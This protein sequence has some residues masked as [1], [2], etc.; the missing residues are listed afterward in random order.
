[1]T[2]RAL[3]SHLVEM[4]QPQNGT[5]PNSNRMKVATVNCEEKI[6]NKYSLPGNCQPF[7]PMHLHLKVS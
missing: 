2:F 4:Y 5:T 3:E 6:L 7:S 1:M